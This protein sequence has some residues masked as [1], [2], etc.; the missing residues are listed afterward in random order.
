MC[1]AVLLFFFVY[2]SKL[3]I[4]NLAIISRI[5]NI[6]EEVGLSHVR[7][8]NLNIRLILGLTDLLR[9]SDLDLASTIFTQKYPCEA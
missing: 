2:V 4:K 3:H 8:S 9:E 6:K 7:W 5:G 1:E